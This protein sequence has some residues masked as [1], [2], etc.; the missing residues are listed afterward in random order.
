MTIQ[1]LKECAPEIP[2]QLELFFRS[3]LYGVTQDSPDGCNEA[4]DRK[5]AAMASDAIYNVTRG[6]FKPWKHTVLGLGLSSI[7]GS[8]LTMQILNRAGHCIN[9]SAAK[10]LETELAYTVEAEERD[11]PDG[12]CL[13][14]NLATAC[15]WD[16]ND[17]D[18][19]TLDG[20]ETLHATV[21]HAYQNI[22]AATHSRHSE[23]DSNLNPREF[24]VGRDRRSFLGKER[25]IPPFRQSL[26][27]AKIVRITGEA[28]PGSSENDTEFGNSLNTEH[29]QSKKPGEGTKVKPS[30]TLLDFYWFS[31]IR[32]GSVPL[33]DGF[34][35]KFIMDPLP[36]QQ[37]CYMDPISSSPTKNE[38]VKETMI[39]TMNVAKETGQDYAVVTYDLAIATKAYSIQAL[40][41]PLFDKLLIMLGNF[42]TELV[43]YGAVGTFIN[44]SGVEFIL[45]EADVLAE[46]SMMGFIKGKFYNRCIRI[47]ELLANVLEMKLY[48]RF[49]STISQEEYE[50][51]ELVFDSIPHD[52]YHVDERLEDPAVLQHI[53]SYEAFFQDTISGSHGATAKYWAIYI[54]M[55]NRLHRELK[56]CV[57]TNDVQ[58]YIDV[59]PAL[60]DIFFALNRPNYAR[61]GTLFLQKLQNAEPEVRDIL[62]S[63]AFSIRRTLKNYSRSAVDLS[64]EQTVNRD[65]AS[66]MKGIVA[67]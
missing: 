57:K 21:G 34:V 46:G 19:E 60:L 47:H 9:Y 18:I 15:V 27:S 41:A 44:E 4:I 32:Q 42:H 35:S 26:K 31:R 67:F 58:G 11:T 28:T 20:K 29:T 6:N 13:L 56:R 22:L 1:K 45:T 7:T 17:A 16:N 55:I 25:E 12:I 64:L 51:F 14:P 3:L 66:Q 54:F 40:E 38:V 53:Q 36:L 65:A 5:V 59:L 30:L 24:Q 49:L 33:H 62:Q 52:T 10:G 43:F 23:S 8:K 2:A 37:I 63:G 48:E 61:W 39:R 50:A